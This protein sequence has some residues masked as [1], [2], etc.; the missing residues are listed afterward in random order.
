M[1]DDQDKE[2]VIMH[3]TDEGEVMVTMPDGR[4][5]FM[6]LWDAIKLMWRAMRC[7]YRVKARE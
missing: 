1:S 6:G 5:A 7:G 2:T 3:A 4:T